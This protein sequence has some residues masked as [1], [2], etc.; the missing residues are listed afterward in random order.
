[1]ARKKSDPRLRK[2]L[3]ELQIHVNRLKKLYGHFTYAPLRTVLSKSKP[4]KFVSV[5]DGK[6]RFRHCQ[7]SKWNVCRLAVDSALPTY[8]SVANGSVRTKPRKQQH[9]SSTISMKRPREKS[10]DPEQSAK[11][12]RVL[13]EDHLA[14]DITRLQPTLNV[15][16]IFSQSNRIL[17]PMI[18]ETE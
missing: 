18:D 6:A 9:C 11:R 3:A 8:M 2:S 7:Y 17:L 1:L 15:L 4:F 12:K 13:N 5:I 16:D 10:D 14:S